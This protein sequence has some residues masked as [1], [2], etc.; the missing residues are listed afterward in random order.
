MHGVEFIAQ[1]V[2]SG[3]LRF[4]KSIDMKGDLP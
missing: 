4:T 3:Q 1:A 2:K